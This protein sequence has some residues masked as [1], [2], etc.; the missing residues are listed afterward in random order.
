MHWFHWHEFWV[1][2]VQSWHWE[3]VGDITEESRSLSPLPDDCH[4]YSNLYLPAGRARKGKRHH[5]LTIRHG[6]LAIAE[7][8]GNPKLNRVWEGKLLFSSLYSPESK[9]VR[10]WIRYWKESTCSIYLRYPKQCWEALSICK[11][12]NLLGKITQWKIILPSIYYL[13]PSPSR[14][15]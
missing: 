9:A 14:L 11:D 3:S 8:H 5:Q 10:C 13:L 6:S 1:E 15:L 2:A 12:K 7:S 4:S